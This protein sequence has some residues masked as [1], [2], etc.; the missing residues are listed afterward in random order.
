M[1]TG[2]DRESPAAL[3][4]GKCTVSAMAA[5]CGANQARSVG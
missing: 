2:R 5:K 4:F 1:I 3:A